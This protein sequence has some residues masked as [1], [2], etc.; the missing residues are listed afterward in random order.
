MST[1]ERKLGGLQVVGGIAA[2]FC[3]LEA[4]GMVGLQPTYLSMFRDFGAE[5]PLL[6]RVFLQPVTPLALGLLPTALVVEGIVRGRSEGAQLARTIAAIATAAGLL[7][8][9]LVA[10]YLPILELAGQIK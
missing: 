6:T 10:M 4:V 1:E 8:G 9:F 7:L 5:L 3:V 2:S